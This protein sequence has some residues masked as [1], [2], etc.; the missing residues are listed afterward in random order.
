MFRVHVQSDRGVTLGNFDLPA[1]TAAP[2]PPRLLIGRAED[3]DLRIRH[4]SVSRH[5]C[6]IARD[7]E[8]DWMLLDLGSTMGTLVDGARVSQVP[9]RHGLLARIGPAVLRFE[10]VPVAAMPEEK[11]R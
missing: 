5:H 2:R 6:A 9:V 8:G 4:A 1:G 11:Q 10:T 3:C 7:E